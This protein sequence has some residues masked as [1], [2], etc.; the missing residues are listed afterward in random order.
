MAISGRQLSRFTAVFA[1]GTMVSRVLGMVRDMLWAAVLSGPSRDAFLVAFK[2]PNML[3]DLVGEGAMN[4]AFIP[5]FS[6]TRESD[7]EEAFRSLISGAMT[8]MLLLLGGLTFLGVLFVPV[9]LQGINALQVVT[10][11]DPLDPSQTQLAGSLAR[12]TF[13]YL[14]FIGMTVV[15]HGT[16]LHGQALCHPRVVARAIEPVDH[17]HLPAFSLGIPGCFHGPGLCGRAGG[18]GGRHGAAPR[19]CTMCSPEKP[20]PG[21]P[22]CKSACPECARFSF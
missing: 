14:L 5:V 17:W 9:M 20:G 7:S 2:L 16:P 8:A 22:A 11:A 10:G 6:H 12:W 1:G 18:L 19:V 15:R 3:R 13:P 4:A 21:G